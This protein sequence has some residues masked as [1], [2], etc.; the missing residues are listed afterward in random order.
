[1]NVQLYK[2]VKNNNNET[3]KVSQLSS[4]EPMIQTGEKKC[5]ANLTAPNRKQGDVQADGTERKP[6][7]N[8]PSTCI[9]DPEPISVWNKG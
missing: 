5:I 4:S 8:L 1:M 3:W 7:N 6:N 2:Y 9:F